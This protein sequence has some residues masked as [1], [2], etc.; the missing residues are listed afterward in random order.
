MELELGLKLTSIADE[1]TSDFKIAKDRAGPLFLSRET[2][3]TF[4]LTAHLKG[5]KR[6]NIKID[7][8]KGGTSI[9][10]SGERQVKETVMVG[11]KV[12]KKDTE[13]KGFKKVFRIPDGVILDKIKAMFN[14]DESTLTI[15]MPKQVKGI[16]GT[17]IEEVE[18]KPELVKE[19]TGNLQVVDEKIQKTGTSKPEKDESAPARTGE[20]DRD[21]DEMPSETDIMDSGQKDKDLNEY[22]VIE[23][24][25]SSPGLETEMPKEEAGNQKTVA[26]IQ[27]IT[28]PQQDQQVNKNQVPDKADDAQE[29]QRSDEEKERPSADEL[30][31][32]AQET[33][34]GRVEEE[35]HKPR[36]KRCK[37]CIPIVA[38]STILLSLVVFVF[39]IMRSKN[40]TSRRK[41]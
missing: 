9:A 36:G 10:I 17:A 29:D 37:M 3:A 7:I 28:E 20:E 34:P 18:E 26:E 21:H 23:S 2:E 33:R 13:T 4:I 35:E 41:D 30:S 12:Y 24:T 38:G 31:E 40:Q 19:G 22:E 27:E 6:G 15:T 8:N 39:Q 11:W 16:R 32:E 25:K 5:Y 14:E 1:F